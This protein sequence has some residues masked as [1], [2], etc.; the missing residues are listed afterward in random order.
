MLHMS[1]PVR[2]RH[3]PLQRW[4]VTIRAHGVP[5][6]VY[7]SDAFSEAQARVAAL[8]HWRA[9]VGQGRE[10]DA[11]EVRDLCRETFYRFAAMALGR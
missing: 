10:P 5:G 7:T 2:P 6:F 4:H 1:R 11:I 8:G 3:Q 9:S